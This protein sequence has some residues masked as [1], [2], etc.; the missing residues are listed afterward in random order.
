M[1]HENIMVCVCKYGIMVYILHYGNY[2]TQYIFIY[3]KKGCYF[4]AINIFVNLN[5]AEIK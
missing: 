2:G 1:L 3:S 5:R 4:F